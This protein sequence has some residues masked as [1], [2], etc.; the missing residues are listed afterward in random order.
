LTKRE[1]VNRVGSADIEVWEMSSEKDGRRNLT[2][3]RTVDIKGK[4]DSWML[5]SPLDVSCLPANRVLV[6][7]SYHNPIARFALYVYDVT[8]NSFS[9]IGMVRPELRPPTP[10]LFPFETLAIAPDTVLARYHTDEIR[11]GA[12]DYVYAYDHIRLFSSKYPDGLEI[13]K[14]SINDGNIQTWG[15]K[16]GVLWLQTKDRR[17]GGKEIVWSLDL[18]KIL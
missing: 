10:G 18:T 12:D 17:K 14:L 11:L 7:I 15:M 8:K 5:T 9:D 4:D 16:D 6:G 1:V 3:K 2:K 13:L